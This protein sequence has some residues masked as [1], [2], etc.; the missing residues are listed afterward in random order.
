MRPRRKLDLLR[1]NRAKSAHRARSSAANG[2]IRPASAA[3]RQPRA[4]RT[5]PDPAAHPDERNKRLRPQRRIMTLEHLEEVVVDDA[6]PQQH[7]RVR[8]PGGLR[9]SSASRDERGARRAAAPEDDDARARARQT[10]RISHRNKPFQFSERRRAPHGAAPRRKWR[11]PRSRSRSRP[12]PRPRPHA[13][14]RA[15]HTTHDTTHAAT[16]RRRRRLRARRAAL[17]RSTSGAIPPVAAIASR[18]APLLAA[19]FRIARAAG[20]CA[21]GALLLTSSTSGAASPMSRCVRLSVRV[22]GVHAGA[23]NY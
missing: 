13:R 11:R 15:R 14:P 9:R 10:D 23:F 1:G 7:A 16:P 21:P 3:R 22:R 2:W 18:F 5:R 17:E 6:V 8:F 4:R 20:A 12:R 19:R